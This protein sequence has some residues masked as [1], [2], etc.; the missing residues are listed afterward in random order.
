M[1]NSVTRVRYF[2]HQLLR[3]ADLTVDQTYHRRLRQLHTRL[4]HRWGI[5]EGLDL[6]AAGADSITVSAGVAF[7]RDGNAMVV[8]EPVTLSLAGLPLAPSAP[9]WVTISWS[10]QRA[11]PAADGI[12]EAAR[13]TEIP[14]IAAAPATPVDAGKSLILGKVVRKDATVTAVEGSDR[15]ATGVSEI[16]GLRAEI[17]RLVVRDG[18]ATMAGPLTVTGNTTI[19]APAARRQLSVFGDIMANQGML[20]MGRAD[21]SVA[22]AGE[23]LGGIGFRGAGVQHGQLSFRAGA[24]FELVDRSADGPSLAYK[25]GTYPY[26]DLRVRSA[27]A[28]GNLVVGAGGSGTLQVRNVDGKRADNDN[29]GS[30]YLNANNGMPVQIGSVSKPSALTVLGSVAA[31]GD[32]I[33]GS[34]SNGRV[35]TRHID[36]KATGSDAT[37]TLN[38]NWSTGA[39]VQVGGD[40]PSKLVVYGDVSASGAITAKT[41]SFRID[42]PLDPGDSCLSHAALEGPEHAVLYRGEARL[43]DGLARVELPY[44]FEALTREDGRTVVVTPKVEPGMPFTLLGASAVR[45]GAFTVHAHDTSVAAQEFCW[46][47]TAVRA[48]VAPLAV[49]TPKKGRDHGRGTPA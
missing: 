7:D 24:G 2:D 21:N 27:Y 14:N 41:K 22:T 19:G 40:K 13:W 1:A 36:G 25:S 49:E 46:E 29:P 43:R 33:A 26:A 8:T 18:P 11:E 37:D 9:A 23:V 10:E 30:L 16:D 35:L 15:H 20:L 44:Y 39:P 28:S 48:D 6:T 42:H 47:V 12:G 17:A 31:R 45:D 4:L 5:A 34:G 32:I 38:L 3:A